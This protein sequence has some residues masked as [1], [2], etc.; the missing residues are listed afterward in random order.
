MNAELSGYRLA[1]GRQFGKRPWFSRSS[2]T[3]PFAIRRPRKPPVEIGAAS[4]VCRIERILF[5]AE[6][7]I[8]RTL[9]TNVEMIFVSPPRAQPIKPGR[10]GKIAA[11]VSL[12]RR[13]DKDPIDL[14]VV[15][16]GYKQPGLCRSP[17]G[18]QGLST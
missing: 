5:P 6:W 12:D 18:P 16:S 2:K 7:R 1:L 4:V 9:E 3:G 10:G 11:H 13:T 17:G 15:G 8:A 14:R